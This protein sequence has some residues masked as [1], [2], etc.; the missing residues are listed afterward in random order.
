MSLKQIKIARKFVSDFIYK[1]D[2]TFNTNILKLLLSV[3]VKINNTNSTFLAV[4]CY[5]TLESAASFK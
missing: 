3:V 5:I 2:A 4:Y 1:T